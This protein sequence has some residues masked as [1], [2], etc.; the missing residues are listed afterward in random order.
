MKNFIYKTLLLLAVVLV[1]GACSEDENLTIIDPSATI[2]L[3]ASKTSVELS[4]DLIGQN[5]LT[6]SWTAPDYNFSSENPTYE[7]YFATSETEAT[8]ATTTNLFTKTY[9]VEE[10]NEV[11]LDAA[12]EAE[13]EIDL[14]ITIVSNVG[15]LK[16]TSEELIITVTPYSAEVYYPELYLV[17]DATAAGWNKDNNDYRMFK[18]AEQGG[19]YH[20]TGYFKA[21]SIKIREQ[22]NEWQPQWGIGATAGEL[23]GNPTTQSGDPEA[24]PVENAGYYTFTV[25]VVDLT[26]T[27]ETYDATGATEYETIGTIGSGTVNGWDADID[28]TK[29]TFDPHIWYMNIDL[30]EGGEFKFREN[31]DWATAWGGNQDPALENYGV[32][33][34]NGG[35]NFTVPETGNYSIVFNTLTFRYSYVLND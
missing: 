34:S 28:F 23:A 4:K 10:L 1:F 24:I 13:V 27:L 8:I 7:V 3:V 25:N 35:V 26:Y 2:E 6:L 31:N 17:G 22:K 29:S 32:A 5:A 11:L 20:Y 14:I 16:T 12:F 18:D 33:T 9:T 30:T 15:A 21:G 19:L